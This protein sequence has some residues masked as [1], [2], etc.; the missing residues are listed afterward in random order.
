MEQFNKQIHKCKDIPC[1]LEN[2]K[3]FLGEREAAEETYF[4]EVETELA[5]K[6]LFITE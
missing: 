2:L 3:T 1:F 5:K 4:P 6:V